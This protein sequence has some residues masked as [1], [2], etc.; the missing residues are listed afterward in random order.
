MSL[1]NRPR[2]TGGCQC[3]AVRFLVDGPLDD[4]H[5]CHCR[6]CQKAVGNLYASLVSTGLAK[7]VWTRGEPA[8]FQSSNHAERGFCRECGTPLF[9]E[10]PFGSALMI[11]SF[12]HPEEIA[13]ATAW[14]IEAKMPYADE[15]QSL[16]SYATL[17]DEPEGSAK[18]EL[19]SY[20]HPDHDTDVWPPEEQA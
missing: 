15:I 13:P 10:S 17:D 3:G 16:P 2:Y 5:V 20:Q 14:G 4:P 12:D 19:K 9:Y 8:R 11:G 7:L 1:D 18:H 6:M